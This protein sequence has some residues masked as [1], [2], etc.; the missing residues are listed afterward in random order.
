MVRIYR[1]TST[2]VIAR[3]ENTP[4]SPINRHRPLRFRRRLSP[5]R[6]RRGTHQHPPD[7][8]EH[9][10]RTIEHHPPHAHVMRRRISTRRPDNR[11]PHPR[12][13]LQRH[14]RI[15]C[16]QL[17]RRPPHPQERE[18]TERTHHQHEPHPE[19]H[20][21]APTASLPRMPSPTHHKPSNHAIQPP[22]VQSGESASQPLPYLI[23]HP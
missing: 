15:G 21:P 6:I 18:S 17:I 11:Q 3:D 8:S 13:T 4:L 10:R 5:P 22:A 14:S 12:R 7:D 2:T 1:R 9:R 20:P 19:Q 23:H 16:T